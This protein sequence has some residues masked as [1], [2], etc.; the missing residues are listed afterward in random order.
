VKTL[1]AAAALLVS[2]LAFAQ[3]PAAA[4]RRAVR[5]ETQPIVHHTVT[6]TPSK[7]NTLYQTVDGSISN[8]SGA[9]IFAGATGRGE[10]RRALLAF[11]ITSQIPQGSQVTRV[12]LTLN[13]SASIAGAQ[14]MSLHRV[15]ADWGE[16]ASVAF[17]GFSWGNSDGRGTAAMAGDATW[18]H[19]FFPDQRW[20]KPGG[21]F[22]ATA[23][24]TTTTA[25]FQY[26]WESPAMIARV[27]QWLDQPSTNFGW[28]VI[29]TEPATRTA[30]RF[31]SREIA[32][33]RTAPAL[34]I[35]FD[36]R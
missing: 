18:I 13:V 22:D 21:D 19:T 20:T 9:H 30:K 6:L 17:S 35:E 31:D 26:T 15:T 12:V 36:S 4:R 3:T 29:G 27:Q 32:Q 11:N 1:L 33:Q 2:S 14:P 8:G 25:A 7:D 23:D 16:G 28:I 10:L 34:L 5:P 24:A